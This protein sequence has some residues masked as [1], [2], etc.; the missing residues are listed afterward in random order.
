MPDAGMCLL[1]YFEGCWSFRVIFCC[2]P[3]CFGIFVRQ[4]EMHHAMYA[5][6][7]SDPADRAYLPQGVALFQAYSLE[8]R[9]CM[10]IVHFHK[11]HMALCQNL[12]DS[13]HHLFQFAFEGEVLLAMFSC[14]H[15]MF[16]SYVCTTPDAA[17]LTPHYLHVLTSSS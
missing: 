15:L 8:R 17:I 5:C 7:C 3:D 10:M 1:A 12:M 13:W 11:R 4:G 14:H 6:V 2:R 9:F 16:V